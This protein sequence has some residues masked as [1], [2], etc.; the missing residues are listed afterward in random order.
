[1]RDRDE[2]LKNLAGAPQAVRDA[3][4][5][6]LQWAA[7]FMRTRI[8][9]LASGKIVKRRTGRYASSIRFAVFND[10]LYAV[11]G[12]KLLYARQLELGGTIRPKKSKIGLA[13]PTKHAKTRAGASKKPRD[14]H[15]SF[16][17][18]TR[19]G[20]WILFGRRTARAKKIMPLFV[21]KKSVKQSP[22][23]IF[24][25]A[26]MQQRQRIEDHAVRRIS[27]AI[28]ELFKD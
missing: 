5:R 28:N 15:D 1:M 14:Y 21:F 26:F 12:T 25:T 4:V 9:E 11:V 16:L 7:P 13:I 3:T 8:V 22:K 18:K 27:A 10:Q 2:I 19:G 20:Q 24:A 17:V 23:E 6:H